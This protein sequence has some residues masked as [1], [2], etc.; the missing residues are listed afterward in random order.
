M[1]RDPR[2]TVVPRWAWSLFCSCILSVSGVDRQQPQLSV[3]NSRQR[4]S[5]M[6][7]QN[8]MTRPQSSQQVL[9]RD[10]L[11]GVACDRSWGLTLP[12]LHGN[13]PHLGFKHALKSIFVPSAATP[14]QLRQ[15]ACHVIS[16]SLQRGAFLDSKQKT[17]SS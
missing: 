14:V 15:H 2:T 11:G 10:L 6:N 4:T 3:S 8:A 16:I 5:L 17:L 1:L 9:G 12:S 13:H 7:T